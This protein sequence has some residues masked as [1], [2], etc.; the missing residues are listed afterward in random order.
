MTT[1]TIT[2]AA[3]GILLLCSGLTEFV[4]CTSVP[5]KSDRARRAAIERSPQWHDGRFHNTLKRQDASIWRIIGR[6]LQGVSHTVPEEPLPVLHPA[7]DVFSESP[8][9]GLRITWFGHSSVLIEIDGYRVLTDPVWSERV[10]PF[11]SIG[12][13]RFF[14]PPLPLDKLPRIDAVLIS[15]DHFDHLDKN[16]IVALKDRVSVFATPLG[17]G[18]H[19][20][21][22]GVDPER[23]VE[24]DWWGEVQI[25]TLTL[26]ATPARHFSGR[27]LTTVFLNKTLWSGWSIAGADNRVYYSGDTAM[28]PGFA[29]IGRRLGPFDVTLFEI[30]AYNDLWADVH[31]GPEQAVQA[32]RMVG[33]RLMMPVHWATFDLAMH[34]WVEPGERMIAACK[35]SSV[36][37]VIPR[38]GQAFEPCAPPELNR[39]WPDL[40][41]QRGEEAPVVS[42]GLESIE[43]GSE[44]LN[45]VEIIRCQA[46]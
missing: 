35:A 40:P 29:E 11:S 17:V 38:P 9:S 19:L 31:I 28:F 4:S 6:R 20:E 18:A 32:H 10:S 15:H 14:Q 27:S 36:D 34:S 39:W 46:N 3:A 7:E 8:D 44:G 1:K 23:I 2:H 41:W 37:V 26:T 42:S 33:G 43:A 12:P 30:G 45:Q 24:C 21:A 16:T 25:G 5:T 13:R 22:W